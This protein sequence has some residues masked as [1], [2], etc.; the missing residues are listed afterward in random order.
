MTS[1]YKKTISSFGIQ[2]YRSFGPTPQFFSKFSQINLF[3]GQNNCGKSNVLH[4]V[5]RLF[6]NAPRKSAK[7]DTLDYHLPEAVHGVYIESDYQERNQKQIDELNARKQARRNFTHDDIE[8]L[9]GYYALKSILDAAADG[10]GK[11]WFCFSHKGELIVPQFAGD[12]L[13]VQL[14]EPIL[15]IFPRVSFQ[16]HESFQSKISKIWPHISPES[17]E[18]YS[19]I[20]VPAIRAVGKTGSAPDGFGGDGII[21]RLAELESPNILKQSLRDK[22]DAINQFL[23]EVV[24]SDSA[25]ITVPYERNTIHVRMNDKVLPIESLGSGIHEVIILAVACT[26]HDE[27]VICLE[28]PELHLN[29]LLQ[30]KLI[31]YLQKSTTNQY[32]I[33][34]HSAAFMDVKDA[35]IYHVRLEDGQSKVSHIT[36]NQHRAQVCWD[37]GYHPSDLLQT[38]SIIWVE[39]PSDRIYLNWWLS[40]KAPELLEG[41]HFSIMFYGGQLSHHITGGDETELLDDFISLSRMNR[42][43]AILMDSDKSTARALLKANT[44]RLRKSFE[45]QQRLCWITQGREVENYLPAVQVKAALNQTHPE[46]N[47]A[48]E[49]GV[50]DNRLTI[51]AKRSKSKEVQASKVKVA[52]YITESFQPDFTVLDLGKKLDELI[53]FIKSANPKTSVESFKR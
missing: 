7:L 14:M 8:K 36:A 46:S 45:E 17:K 6:P 16:R 32:F 34:T 5:N 44:Q 2:G 30:K 11:L 48:T 38:N 29:P 27:T 37:L 33:T 15:N 23:R 4:V 12:I 25:T 43:S 20:F 31:R 41:V 10:D 21:E 51:K 22:F 35:E 9:Q 52:Q 40:K 39:G 19:A 24:D 3:I 1:N 42:N 50:Y 28:E 47:I 53:H 26:L 49:L 18:T 13:P